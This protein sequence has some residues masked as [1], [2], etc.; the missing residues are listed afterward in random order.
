MSKTILAPL[1]LTL[2][3]LG[4]CREPDNPEPLA[5][6]GKI[7]LD[8]LY[9]FE[10]HGIDFDTL[11]YVNAAGNHLLFSE[12]QYFISDITLHYTDGSIYTIDKWKDIFYTDSDIPETQF[13]SIYDSIPAGTCDSLTFTFGINEEKNQSFMYVNPPESLMFWPDILGGGYHYMKLNGKWL[14]GEQSLSPFNFHLGIG[15]VYDDEGEI[16]GFIQNYFSVCIKN[17]AFSVNKNMTV[18]LGIVMNVEKWFESPNTWDFNVWGGDIMQNQ[19]AMHT[20]C[21]NGS[22]VFTLDIPVYIQP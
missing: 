14:N 6:T 7:A 12:I 3:M 2:V 4:S 20:A 18:Q 1:L 17:M 13:Q 22:D 21:V 11:L 8:F 10:G 16:T 19:E 5:D 15:Q 9:R